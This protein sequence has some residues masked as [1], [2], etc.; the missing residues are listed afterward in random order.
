[1]D[2]DL[3]FLFVA[4][5][6]FINLLAYGMMGADK[7]RAKR[8]QRRIPEARLF[9]AAAAFGALGAW[10]GMRVWR[11]KTKHASFVVGIPVLLAV[12]VLVLVWLFQSMR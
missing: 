12:N 11:H 6:V 1:M 8:K 3:I 7:R 9:L 10:L 5:L 4:Y 2:Q